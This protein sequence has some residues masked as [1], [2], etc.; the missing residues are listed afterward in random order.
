MR[1]SPLLSLSGE[2]AGAAAGAAAGFSAHLLWGVAVLFWPL[3]ADMS[4]VSI[5]AHRMIWSCVFMGLLLLFAGQI[6]GLCSLTKELKTLRRIFWSAVLLGT[7]WS[8]F[9]WAV[10]T[11]QVIEASL[12]YFITPLLNVLM[13]RI[14]LGERLSRLQ[15]LAIL[16]AAAGV[17][18]SVAAYGRVPLTGLCLAGTF[19]MYGYLQKTIRVAPLPGFFA[20]TL[21]LAPLAL[22]WLACMEQGLGFFGH[23]SVRQLQLMGTV[24]FTA[25]PLLFFGYAA[26]HVTLATIGILQYV[27]PSLNFLL[28]VTVLGETMKAPDRIAFPVIWLALAIYTWD[29]L[30]EFRRMK[31]RP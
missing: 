3:L 5:M 17:T 7:N 13:G 27:S 26:R 16:L 28:A 31:E 18:F 30:H 8:I 9:L 24:L 4:P 2:R 15:A 21:L 29:A 10:N 19:A 23:G 6:R 11:G 12:G 22:L 25:V 20:Q 1:F 14:L